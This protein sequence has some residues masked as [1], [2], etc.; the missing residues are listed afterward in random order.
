LKEEKKIYKYVNLLLTG[1]VNDVD[2]GFVDK[3]RTIVTLYHYKVKKTV[4]IGQI[5]DFYHGDNG[6]NDEDDFLKLVH[7]NYKKD[8]IDEIFTLFQF[9]GID[10]VTVEILKEISLEDVEQKNYGEKFDKLKILKDYKKKN[11]G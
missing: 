1:Y 10:H 7:K 4:E 6:L 8:L 3:G 5:F 2:L 9:S 11:V